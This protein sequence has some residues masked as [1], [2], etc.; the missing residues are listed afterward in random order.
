M[1]FLG[2][3]L[4]ISY[5][6]IFIAPQS[7]TRGQV[8]LTLLCYIYKNFNE[9][10]ELSTKRT[11]LLLDNS[12][13]DDQTNLNSRF[14]YPSFPCTSTLATHITRFAPIVSLSVTR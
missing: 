6:C 9:K 5:A 1:L 4:A 11:S 2:G 13:A 7:T 12:C 10:L 3:R 8:I 14:D